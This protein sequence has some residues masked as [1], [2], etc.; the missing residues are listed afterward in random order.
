M[1]PR[2]K[3]VYW[4]SSVFLALFQ[5]GDTPERLHQREQAVLLMEEARAGHTL[6]V[7]SALTIAEARRGDGVPPL[8][9]GEHATLRAFMRH[10]FIEVVP[11]DRAIGEI[12]ADLGEQF[13]LHPND[14]VQ[15]ATA[16]HLH[17]SEFLTWDQHFHR[18]ERMVGAPVTI[19]E[20][21]WVGSRQ[22]EIDLGQG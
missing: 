9:G 5:K 16:T 3:R 19:S 4:D 11:V 18:R 12:A 7:T 2:A 20:P 8:P 6:I 22:L 1:P 13:G 14:A 21:K 15:L 17:I 10:S